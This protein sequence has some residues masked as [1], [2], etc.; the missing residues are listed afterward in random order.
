MRLY[1]AVTALFQKPHRESKSEINI[2]SGI[3]IER[4][5]FFF[6][7]NLRKPH[8]IGEIKRKNRLIERRRKKQ[9]PSNQT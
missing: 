5:F 7:S 2:K 9:T 1:S 3:L 6:F 8:R 4:S